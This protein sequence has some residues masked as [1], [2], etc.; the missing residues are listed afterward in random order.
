M[1]DLLNQLVE[2]YDSVLVDSPPVLLVADGSIMATEVH[3]V[4]VVVDGFKTRSSS[5]RATLDVFHNAHVDVLGV[6]VNK[7]KPPRLGVGY[8]HPYHN[9]SNHTYYAATDQAY[10]NGNRRFFT[11][12]TTA[13][14]RFR[15]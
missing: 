7:L 3:G 8:L 15:K 13:L 2:E 10:G 14:A 5:L 9:Y 12:A 11:K 6:I 4:I 1:S